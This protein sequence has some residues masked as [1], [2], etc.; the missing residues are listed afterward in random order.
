MPDILM[1]VGT[2][3]YK[4]PLRAARE[5]TRHGI[6]KR[7]PRKAIPYIEPGK[8]NLATYHPRALIWVRNPLMTLWDLA[9][10]LH[11]EHGAVPEGFVADD[12]DPLALGLIDEDGERNTLLLTDLLDKAEQAGKLDALIDKYQ[13]EFEHGVFGYGPITAIQYVAKDGEKELPDDLKDV[14]GMEIVRDVY[15][16]DDNAG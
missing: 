8:T 6:S 2:R 9:L 12:F 11:T 13:L 15:E 1:M 16:E 10:E 4:W 3:Y 5:Y 7:V 14:P